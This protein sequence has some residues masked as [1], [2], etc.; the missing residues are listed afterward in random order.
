MTTPEST[1]FHPPVSTPGIVACNIRLDTV[2]NLYHMTTS[3]L[4]RVL[5]HTIANLYR[6]TTPENM[7]HVQYCT[8]L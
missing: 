3:E 7:V 2:A 6:V 4:L 1:T 5:V 8:Q